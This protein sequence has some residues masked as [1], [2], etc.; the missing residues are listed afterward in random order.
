MSRPLDHIDVRPPAP[1]P[2]R[3]TEPALGF[4]GWM[5]WAWR[6]LTSMRVAL[7]LLL[8]LALAAVPG[9]LVP[10][11]SSDPNGVVQYFK[12]N[13]GL[14]PMLDKLQAF[15]AYTSFW[16]S[17]IYLLLFISLIGCVLP[18]TIHHLR[19][20]RATPPK[21]P[22]RLSRMSGYTTIE[23]SDRPGAAS[24]AA[25]AIT[26][27][28]TILRKRG[29]RV[30]AFTGVQT[31]Q[32][33]ELSVSAERGYLREAGNL[34]FHIALIGVLIT[35]G[36]GGGFGFNGNRVVVEGQSMIN[37]LA[38]YDS[39]N[40][41]RFF[42]PAEL[43]PY[44]LTLNKLAVTYETQNKRARG[45]P[46]DYTATV[47]TQT[48]GSPERTSR[49]IKVND[50]LSIGGT[51][52]YLL[53][54]GYAP[55]ITVRDPQGHAVFSDFIPFLPQDANLTSLG[56]VKVPDGLVKQVGLIGF[57]YPTKSAANTGAFYSSYP[58]LTNPVL[59]LNAYSGDLGINTGA[60]KSVYALDT[61]KLT[62][63]TG[64]KTGVRS[65]ELK[66]GQTQQLPDGLGSITLD[67]VSRFASF[68][69]HHDP[70]QGWVLFFAIAALGGLL[71]SLFVPRRRLWVK[72]IVEGANP[73]RIE[74]AGLARGDDPQLQDAV[75]DL[76]SAHQAAFRT[77]SEA[78]QDSQRNT[79][80]KG[81]P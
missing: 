80:Q 42:S 6:Q 25:T 73:V 26:T 16:F 38:A 22:A 2:G 8:L 58:D 50:P 9:S 54:N 78:D 18:R 17:S 47:T 43:T 57:F 10:Q 1:G 37:T 71:T 33:R 13:P 36:I 3:I 28:A 59:T 48:Q 75:A 46:T 56:V 67:G 19:S 72:A 12:N 74:Y 76:A 24:S 64:G 34:T 62:Q 68:E 7:F 61:T 14:A 49:T 53:G 21:T 27:A 79:D 20:L 5:R 35:V 51:D 32:R 77:T 52:V 11:R 45:L 44:S 31:A 65:I 30:A 41:G 23:L 40:P 4:T 81:T 55:R 63:L 66:P 69:I 29:Y 15:D 70:A 39:F 60:P